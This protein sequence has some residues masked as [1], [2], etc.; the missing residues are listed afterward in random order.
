MAYADRK[1]PKRIEAS[2]FEKDQLRPRRPA[3]ARPVDVLQEV[4][5]EKICFRLE[6]THEFKSSPVSSI[7]WRLVVSF[8][9]G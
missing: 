2:L 4:L 9:A 5:L 7:A 1:I 8:S 3:P 6:D